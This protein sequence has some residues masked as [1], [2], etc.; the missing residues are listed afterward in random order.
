MS[1][2]G[3]VGD[4]ATGTYQVTR[5]TASSWSAE[6]YPVDGTTSTIAIEASVQPKGS[7]ADVRVDASGRRLDYQYVVYT[8]TELRTLSPTS[9]PDV[10]TIGGEPHEVV[11]VELWTLDDFTHC[12]AYVARN[13]PGGGP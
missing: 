9:T 10:V 4:F 6:G 7:G 12:R 1:L 2:E 8:E 5:R 11:A 3:V 13:L